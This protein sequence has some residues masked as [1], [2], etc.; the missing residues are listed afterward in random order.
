MKKEIKKKWIDALR[1]GEYK[2]TRGRLRFDDCYCALGVLADI[3]VKEQKLDENGLPYYWWIDNTFHCKNGIIGYDVSLPYPF[4]KDT[5]LEYAELIIHANDINSES[6][7]QIA[8]IIE[9]E[10]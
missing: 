5:G 2:Q 4:R 10:F 1:S 6:F 7:G 8:D 3:V 9:K